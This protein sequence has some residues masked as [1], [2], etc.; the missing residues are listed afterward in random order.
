[1]ESVGKQA[2]S[3]CSYSDAC[4]LVSRRIFRVEGMDCAHE[5]GPILS[6]LFA[7]PGGGRA[8]PSYGD[9]T[10]TVEFDPHAVSPER[11]VQAISE[12]GFK[13]DI[14]ERTAEEL[15]FWE[16]Y[17]RLVES[18][19]SGIMLAAGLLLRFMGVQLPWARLFLI[20]A[21]VSGGWFVSRRARP[22]LPAPPI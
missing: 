1:M 7:V 8:V 2:V 17:G 3:N 9:S 14:D 13:A 4:S 5:S 19:A 20:L 18:S 15:P 11:I 12:A 21:T 16:R 22:G 10:L 6:M